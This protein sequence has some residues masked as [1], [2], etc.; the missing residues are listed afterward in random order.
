VLGARPISAEASATL[1]RASRGA[2]KVKEAE[3]LREEQARSLD[4][5]R[6]GDAGGAGLSR[7]RVRREDRKRGFEDGLQGWTKNSHG[8]GHWKIYDNS[9]SPPVGTAA[10]EGTHAIYTEQG[11]PSSNVLYQDVKLG[12]NA[13]EL[14]FMLAYHNGAGVFYTP[15]SLDQGPGE[16]MMKRGDPGP[17]QQF[18]AD[19][20][21]P[22]AP[23]RSVKKADVLK[24]V[25]RTNVGDPVD[26]DWFE[27]TADVSNLAGK[28]V[29]VRFAEVDNQEVF[30]VGVDDVKVTSG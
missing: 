25:Y 4:V 6:A 27:V 3:V 8:D 30:Y 20:M 21:K 10:P 14:S 7:E 16:P 24:K 11:G 15:K 5:D 1:R 2:L 9:A 18:R 13:T 19:L 28:K 22:S 26:Q 17:N 23:L 29:R 12:Q